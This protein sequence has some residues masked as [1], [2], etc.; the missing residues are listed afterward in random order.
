MSRLARLVYRYE[1]R[2]APIARAGRSGQVVES[3][4]VGGEAVQQ[5]GATGAD[6]IL[7]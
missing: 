6:E 7:L 3:A 1:K 5:A 4:L 2:P